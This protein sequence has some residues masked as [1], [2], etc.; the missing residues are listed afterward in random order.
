MASTGHQ[1]DAMK[2]K[3]VHVVK[4][5]VLTW[6]ILQTQS[7]NI[8][9]YDIYLIIVMYDSVHNSIMLY[10]HIHTKTHKS[11]LLMIMELSE[12]VIPRKISVTSSVHS[13]DR[14]PKV[15]V[16][17]HYKVSTIVYS[18]AVLSRVEQFYKVASYGC[19]TNSMT[20]IK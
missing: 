4:F 7:H 18:L 3:S 11:H 2:L 1:Y 9:K 12:K 16:K 10:T 6:S 13:P 5:Y 17:V 20:A 14:I 15:H 19:S 8:H